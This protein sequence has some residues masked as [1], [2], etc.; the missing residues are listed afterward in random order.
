MFFS[1][2][3]PSFLGFDPEVILEGSAATLRMGMPYD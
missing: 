2:N 1:G 3:L